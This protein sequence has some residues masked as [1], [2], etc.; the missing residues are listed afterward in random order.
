[1][2]GFGLSK[3]STQDTPHPKHLLLQLNRLQSLYL[4]GC[5]LCSL[6]PSRLQLVRVAEAIITS[7]PVLNSVRRLTKSD[8]IWLQT[9]D[10]ASIV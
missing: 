1:M 7:H 2:E 4:L 10:S 8:V 3:L 5:T 6:R 9:R